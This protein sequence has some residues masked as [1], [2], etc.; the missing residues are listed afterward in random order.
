MEDN[1]QI[2]YEEFTYKKQFHKLNP[3]HLKNLLSGC[4]FT[5]LILKVFQFI[6]SNMGVKLETQQSSISWFKEP[7]ISW[8]E[9]FSMSVSY[10]F[11]IFFKDDLK[12]FIFF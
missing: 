3:I 9:R 8:I 1:F 11:Y 5:T 7:E 2:L 10:I 4:F 12:K 6:I